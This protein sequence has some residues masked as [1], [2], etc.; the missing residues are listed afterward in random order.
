MPSRLS[1]VVG[2][3]GVAAAAVAA[4]GGGG[5]TT[6]GTGAGAQGGH[7]SSGHGASSHGG[8]GGTS[9]TT[10][11]GPCNV[12]PD[13]DGDGDGW[14][15]AEGDCD[16]CNPASNPGAVDVL[17]AQPEGDPVV[18]DLDCDGTPAVPQPCDEGLALD[19]QDPLSAARA[20]DLCQTTELAPATKQER[21]WGLLGARWVS[22]SGTE[23]R[24]PGA[25]AGIL[26]SFGKGAAVQ[27]G[28]RMLAISTGRARTPDQP[29]ACKGPS[30]TVTSNVDPPEG[31]PQAVPGCEGGTIINDDVAL[32]VALR[33]PTNALGFAFALK[34]HS[35]EYPEWVCTNYNDQF[36]ALVSPPP[37]A[38]IHGNVAFDAMLH[39]VSV[40]LSFF[41]VCDPASMPGFASQCGAAPGCPSAPSPYC[42]EGSGAL[43][44]TG[45]DTWGD[46]GATR[47]LTT[48]APVKGGSDITV[49]FAIWDTTDQ[50]YDSTV[51]LDGFSWITSGPASVSTE[52]IPTPP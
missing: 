50:A 11:T 45:F 22:A 41:D 42:A 19:D 9:G 6:L 36:V 15:P 40:N 16:D 14:T 37:A 7:T 44:G 25:Q 33:T 18:L 27:T 34:F 38:S 43:D 8:T 5:E 31:F 21:R 13:I 3:A 35:F 51:L 23:T 52:P 17:V 46:A 10:V 26:S 12:G 30:C 39:P 2:F 32:E 1:I 28:A 29:D 47:W 4:C 49:R 48:R 24:T 20:L